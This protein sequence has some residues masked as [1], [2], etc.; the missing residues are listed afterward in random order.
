VQ[1]WTISASGS[2]H[3]LA[4][5][6]RLVVDAAE[7]HHGR[8]GALGAE[9]REGLGVAALEE[10]RHRQH[11]GARH[12]ALAATAVNADLEQGNPP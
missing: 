9:A 4:Q 1:S 10:R 12:D 6:D 8:A 3:R 2:Q 7:G 11:L 5:A